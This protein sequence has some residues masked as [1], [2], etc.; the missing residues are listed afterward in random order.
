MSALAALMALSE[1]HY[2]SWFFF[3]E[4]PDT[5][6]HKDK[7]HS[8]HYKEEINFSLIIVEGNKGRKLISSSF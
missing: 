4:I 8:F 7:G 3:S 2:T 1:S 5:K 6:L